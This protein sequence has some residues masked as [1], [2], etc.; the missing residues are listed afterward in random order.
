MVGQCHSH[1]WSLCLAPCDLFFPRWK[2]LSPHQAL[3]PRG[4]K[5]Q[6]ML[7]MGLRSVSHD[8]QG[9]V[10]GWVTTKSV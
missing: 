10:E 1:V 4:S 6:L 5:C 7:P 3:V 2:P 9:S 8:T